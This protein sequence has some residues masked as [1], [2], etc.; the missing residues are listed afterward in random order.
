MFVADDVAGRGLRCGAIAV[1][2]NVFAG[3]KFGAQSVRLAEL[4]HELLEL[5]VMISGEENQFAFAVGN[6]EKRAQFVEERRDRQRAVNDVAEQDDTFGLVV[7]DERG[8]TFKGVIFWRDGHELAL[9]AMG[10]GI[11]QMQ[12]CDSEQAMLAKVNS[13]AR[14]EN[15]AEQEFERLKNGRTRLRRHRR[16]DVISAFAR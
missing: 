9:C 11:T 3:Q 5:A 4:F 15:D 2:E 1:K 12:I 8:K 14:V 7:R 13:A 6:C 10:P 16:R